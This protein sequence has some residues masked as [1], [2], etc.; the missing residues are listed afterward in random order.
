MGFIKDIV[1]SN[2]S[3]GVTLQGL[4]PPQVFCE[5]V[6]GI[7]HAGYSHLWI[8]DSSLH[9]R[10]AY[11]Y[12]TLAAL[13]SHR[14]LLGT[15][16]THPFTRHPAVTANSI[17]TLHEI[18]NGRAVLGVGSGDRPHRELGFGPAAPEVV[19]EMITVCRRLLAGERISFEG[20]SF[21]LNQAELHYSYHPQVPIYIACSGPR[22]LTLAGEVADG[23]IIHCGL[24]PEALDFALEKVENGAKKAGRNLKD[25]DLWVMVCGSLSADRSQALE[26]SRV[27]AAWFAQTAP[28]CCKIAGLDPGLIQKIQMAYGGAEF[29]Q[30]R[31]A[32]SLVPDEMI[33]LFT[34]GAIPSE[35]RRRIERLKKH[36]VR[37]FNFMPIGPERTRSFQLFAE[38][39]MQPLSRENP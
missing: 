18:S 28:H 32:A 8:T 6:R 34:L 11:E 13:N 29:H 35:A 24:F 16:T 9:A 15:C 30:A 19:R 4:E 26:G 33:E 36:G 7:E 5:Q 25:L 23:V 39:V 2:G 10:G 22:M 38:H 20:Q 1:N 12:L 3:W 37:N 14:I 17:A 31:E 21:K 27:M